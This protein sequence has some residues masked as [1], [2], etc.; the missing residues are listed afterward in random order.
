MP[1]CIIVPVLSV[2]F[3][4]ISIVLWIGVIVAE[5]GANATEK[6]KNTFLPRIEIDLTLEIKL[7]YAVLNLIYWKCFVKCFGDFILSSMFSEW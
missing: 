3:A 1:S 2:L 5:L 7:G 6:S 4:S